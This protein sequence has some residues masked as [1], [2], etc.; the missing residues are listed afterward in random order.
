ML[1]EHYHSHQQDFL[2]IL[3]NNYT[4]IEDGAIWYSWTSEDDC[5]H[6]NPDRH[7]STEPWL[8]PVTLL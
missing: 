4:I 3:N 6:G 1:S 7:S 5:N 2:D 8:L